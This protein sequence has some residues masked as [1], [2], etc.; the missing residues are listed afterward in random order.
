M[1]Y[2]NV[3]ICKRMINMDINV[4]MDWKYK[5]TLYKKKINSYNKKVV[6]IDNRNISEIF[7][8]LSYYINKGANVLITCDDERYLKESILKMDKLIKDCALELSNNIFDY[9]EDLMEKKNINL[10]DIYYRII[11]L[12]IKI[13]RLENE[14]SNINKSIS[15]LKK[16]KQ[17]YVY[18][19]ILKFLSD[20][21]EYNIIGDKI[22]YKD[23]NLVTDR[24]YNYLIRFLS[25][26]GYDEI[27]YVNKYKNLFLLLPSSQK[28]INIMDRLLENKRF[29]EYDEEYIK[30]S[31]Y[32]NYVSDILALLKFEN[33]SEKLRMYDKGVF[34]NE[35]ERIINVKNNISKYNKAY[36]YL[37][38]IKRMY[39]K[40]WIRLVN[41][42][43]TDYAR[44]N[45]KFSLCFKYAKQKAISNGFFEEKIN[46][47]ESKLIQCKNRCLILNKHLMK[48]KMKY[49]NYIN[50]NENI[51]KD[52]KQWI[53]DAVKKDFRDNI[54][55]QKKRFNE[56][57]NIFPLIIAPANIIEMN[58]EERDVFD[59]SIMIC[60]GRLDNVSMRGIILRSRK[61]ISVK[62][63]YD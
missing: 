41:A 46:D 26:S 40:L 10:K 25:I 14:I 9:S 23:K 57:L 1:V 21:K 36:K 12:K 56:I 20:H 58:S 32:I 31:A 51:K 19:D 43:K 35:Y 7:D 49:Y 11:N 13:K 28:L 22:S 2:T 55:I 24:E 8:A 60:S 4:S 34:E 27:M 47:M 37:S 38:E 3:K 17:K 48:D 16:E 53:N 44:F 5:D 62:K 30:N 52:F 18:S 29:Y 6:C 50:I 39:P 15:E 61:V 42:K 45:Q 59:I 63:Q 54:Y 33:A